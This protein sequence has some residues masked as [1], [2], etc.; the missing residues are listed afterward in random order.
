MD[1]FLNEQFGTQR[2]IVGFIHANDEV[3]NNVNGFQFS[4]SYYRD[5]VFKNQV[6]LAER[7]SCFSVVS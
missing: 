1:E 6:T 4:R 7:D 5:Q 3:S 2:I